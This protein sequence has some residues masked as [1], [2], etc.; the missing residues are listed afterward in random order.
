MASDTVIETA[1]S[2]TRSTPLS[3]AVEQRDRTTL[4]MVEKAIRSKN[5]RLA[6]QPVVQAVDQSRPKFFEGLIRVLD[7]T[8]RVIPARDFI[9]VIETNEIGRIID[10]LALELGL[11]ALAANPELRLSINLSARSIGYR[12][13]TNTLD[14]GIARIPSLRGRLILEI[15]EA[16]AM[17]MPDVVQAFMFGLQDKGILFA[18]DDFGAGYTSFRYLKSFYFDI[19]K[20]DGQFIRDINND[21]DNQVLLQ[22]LVDIGRHFDMITVAEAV[23]TP[24][25]AAFLAACGVDCLQGYLFGAPSLKPSWTTQK[26]EKLAG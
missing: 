25:E 9:H 1:A 3:F 2:D 15:T 8:G 22:A 26:P 14:Q 4:K 6:Y 13:W 16:S 11:A 12:R 19:L 5:V 24:R 20:I 7:D 17:V 18:L 21:A 10:C 23:E